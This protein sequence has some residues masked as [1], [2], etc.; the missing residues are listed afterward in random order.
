MLTIKKIDAAKEKGRI[1]DGGG[2]YLQVQTMLTGLRRH[3][4]FVISCLADQSG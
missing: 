1:S 3:G 2:L 4:C